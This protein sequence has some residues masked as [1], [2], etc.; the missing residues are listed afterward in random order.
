MHSRIRPGGEEK[1]IVKCRRVVKYRQ[2]TKE[3]STNTPLAS[4]SFK[5]THINPFFFFSPMVHGEALAA[6]TRFLFTGG[7][8][9][10]QFPIATVKMTD[11]QTAG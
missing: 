10:G 9:R 1:N 6:Q 2:E 5:L 7:R 4:G 8:L 11:K 3:S